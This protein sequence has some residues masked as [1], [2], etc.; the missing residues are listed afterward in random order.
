MAVMARVIGIPARMAVGFLKPSLVEGTD[1]VWEYSAHDL[2]AWPE[3]YFDGFGWVRFEPTPGDRGGGD[4]D[5]HRRTRDR[6]GRP[7]GAH[8]VQSESDEHQPGARPPSSPRAAQRRTRT[9]SGNDDDSAFPWVR[10]GLGLGGGALLVLL[11]LT[12]RL[13]RR[14]ARQL[15][16]VA[17]PGGRLGGAARDRNWT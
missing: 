16:L 2:H 11:A 8:R 4:A 9:P 14:R 10:V 6:R 1:D 7:G 17:G 15:R 13:L 5:V 3:L 12:P